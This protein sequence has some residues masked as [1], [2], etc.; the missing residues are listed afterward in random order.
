MDF[1]YQLKSNKSFEETRAVLKS[2]LSKVGFGVLWELNFKDK[3]SEKGL[4]FKEDFLVMEV[5][6]PS[7]AKEVLEIDL[8]MGFM[9][10]CKV[11]VYTKENE[12]FVG[13]MKPSALVDHV[14]LKEVAMKVEE[15]LKHAIE[16][17]I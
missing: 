1:I 4:E 14:Q 17:A 5:C 9:L 3:L 7:K 15:D 10:P 8:Q 2:E 16:H 12:V 6:N 11:G 13:M